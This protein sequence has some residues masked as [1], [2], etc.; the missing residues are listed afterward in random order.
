VPTGRVPQRCVQQT[1]L[2]AA[3]L[4]MLVIE[5]TQESTIKTVEEWREWED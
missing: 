3:A 1:S 5:L 2:L 4:W